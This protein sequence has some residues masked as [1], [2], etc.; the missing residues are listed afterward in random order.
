MKDK[1]GHRGQSRNKKGRE[2]GG[3]RKEEGRRKEGGGRWN[4]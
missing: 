3:G 1:E 4:K 2:E